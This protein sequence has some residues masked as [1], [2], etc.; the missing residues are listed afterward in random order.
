MENN[1]K[2]VI[3]YLELAHKNCRSSNESDNL[4]K[5]IKTL[6]FN[7]NKLTIKKKRRMNEKLVEIKQPKYTN[8]EETLKL[9]EQ[10]IEKEK[11]K[12]KSNETIDN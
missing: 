9:I 7:F 1:Y 6:I 12:G 4:K 3:H 11:E 5:I 2:M 10:L 8:P